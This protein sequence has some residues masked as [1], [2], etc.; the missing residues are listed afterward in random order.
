[1]RHFASSRF[2]ACYDSLPDHLQSLADKNF[3]LLK[4]DPQHPSLA[5]KRVNRFWSAR[6]GLGHR[7]LAVE[8]D[9]DLIWF[10]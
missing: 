4:A 1:M 9:G 6:V 2:W 7:A 8:D 5:F 3:A 10:W